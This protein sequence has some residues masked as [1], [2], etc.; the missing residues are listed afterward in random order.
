[1]GPGL[2]CEHM[3]EEGV[4]AGGRTIREVEGVGGEGAAYPPT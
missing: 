3:A 4:G 2:A 1:M